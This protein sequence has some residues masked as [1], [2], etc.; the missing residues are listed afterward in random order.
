[1]KWDAYFD[2]TVI[3][4]L[5][6]YSFYKQKRKQISEATD[7]ALDKGYHAFM[8]TAIREILFTR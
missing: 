3:E 2:M 5:N 4:G 6:A 1:M 7:Q 8:V